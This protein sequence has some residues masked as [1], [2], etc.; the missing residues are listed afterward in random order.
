MNVHLAESGSGPI[1][2]DQPGTYLHWSIFTVSV[3]NLAL[4][5]VMVLIFGAAL[6]LPFPKGRNYP[7]EEPAGG[8]L[9]GSGPA[10]GAVDVGEDADSDMWTSRARRLAL[11][12][13]P[14]GKLLPDRQ[15]GYVASWAYVFGVASLAALGVAIVSGFA[16]ALGGP[17]WWRYNLVGHF[18]NSLHLWSVELFMALLVIHL[19]AKF[20]MA[21]WRGKRALT[22]ITGVVAFMAAV[23]ECFSGYVSQQNFDSQWISASGK[24]AFNSVGVGAF[25]NVMNFGQMLLWH[26]VLIPIVLVAIVGAHVLLVRV[27]GVSHPL[28]AQAS[29][30]RGAGRQ[31]RRARAAADAAPWR[32]PTRRYDILKEGTVAGCIVL[33]LT[34]ALAAL[35]SSPNVPSITIQSWAKVA[36]ADFLA[37]AA[38]ELNGTSETAT[39]G[40]PYNH[41]TGSVQRLLFSP[42]QL[43]GV[44]QPIEP[45]QDFV[46]RPLATISST[47]TAV[48]AALATYQ[49]APAAKQLAWAN[50]Y[51]NAVTHVTFPNG[52][53]VVPKAADGPVPVMLANELTM[54]RSGGLDASLLAK[55]PFYG[56]NFTGPLLFLEDGAYFSTKAEGM[57]LTGEQWGVMNETGSYPGQPWLWLY[58]LWYQVP[59]FSASAN[60]DMIA[61]Y[62][63]GLGTLLLLAVPFIPGL[64]DVPRLI[65]VHR[66]IWRRWGNPAQQGAGNEPPAGKS[67]PVGT[68]ATTTTT[69]GTATS[70]TATSGTAGGSQLPPRSP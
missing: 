15:P 27:R 32:G 42:T 21:A 45:A 17:D 67:G 64:R 68:A 1:N 3:A 44:R 24:D 59:G 37:T 35:L 18:F 30:G 25:F 54:A 70:G 62:M 4:I 23:V 33:V 53:P 63:T 16:I 31:G 22:W 19:W 41:Q 61:V 47:N 2:M 69:A 6:L 20:W 11:R 10:R 28:P 13:L 39:Y 55:Q 9:P 40:P 7:A 49:A 52:N 60:V 51:G 36:P 34:L 58:T 8:S 48:A 38:T 57:N 26:V 50:A 65:P 56:T 29:A 14:P 66:L 43:A 12:L 46:L 5:G